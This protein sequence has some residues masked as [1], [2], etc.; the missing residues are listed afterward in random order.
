MRK[1]RLMADVLIQSGRRTNLQHLPQLCIELQI[2]KSSTWK[3]VANT[4]TIDPETCQIC[5]VAYELP[6]DI[7]IDNHWVNCGSKTGCNWWVHTI[8]ANIHYPN[9]DEGE[10]KIDAWAS[11]H[12]YCIKHMPKAEKI[13]W[14]K[15]LN[16]E[17]QLVETS[18]KSRVI[19]KFQRKK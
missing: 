9:N 10:T 14:D 8:C 3:T 13:G 7:E 2:K 15:E 5:R 19:L 11:K 16:R 17:V 1:E 12:F 4:S 18:K 6:E